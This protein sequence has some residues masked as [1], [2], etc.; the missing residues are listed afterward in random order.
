M[1]E[2]ALEA[3]AA[4]RRLGGRGAAVSARRAA[5]ALLG[6]VAVSTVV[7]YLLARELHGPFVFMDEL[8]YERMALSLARSGHFDLFGH[9]G[10]AYSPLYPALLAPVYAVAHSAATADRAVVALNAL[11]MS[12]AAVP[13][14]AIARSLLSRR[15][16]LGAAALSLAAP[17]MYYSALRLSEA[18]AYPLFLAAVWA[19]LRTLREPGAGNDALLLVAIALA[20]GARL[21]Q[22]ALVPA[23]LTAIVLVELLSP[24]AGGRLR[25]V[26]RE[27]ARHRLL[28][29]VTV[30]GA[31][32]V[33]ARTLVNG[34][35]LPLAGRYAV[36][37]N[38]RPSPLRV[39][40]LAVRHLAGLDLAVGVLPFA[41]ALAAAWLFARRGLP[42]TAVPFAAIALACTFW[43]VLEVA[44]DAAAFDLPGLGRTGDLPRIH[45]RYL[46]YLVPF[47]LV[48][49]VASLRARPGIRTL[50]GAAAAAAALPAAIPF[51]LVVN[52]TIVADTFSLQALA[53]VDRNGL[54]VPVA[55]A[56][57]I[58]VGAAALLAFLYAFGAAR[59]PVLAVLATVAVFAYVS[60]AERQRLLSAA[61][62]P[63]LVLPEQQ[64]DWVD[65]IV[66]PDGSVAILDAGRARPLA[67]RETAYYNFS[68]SRVYSACRGAFGG[69]FGERRVTVDSGGAVWS[70]GALLRAQY[71]VAD[72]SVQPHGRMLAANLPG[73][74][75]LVAPPDGIVQVGSGAA[76]AR[77][78]G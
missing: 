55:D 17:L 39:A 25:S 27:L 51:H 36:V 18:L 34:G 28:V 33:L 4:A 58:A 9:T 41:A 30:A 78:R 48:A 47:F 64:H 22:V 76:A 21:Q 69:D 24:P 72:S 26:L 40:E 31:L 77:C 65:R 44:Y 14:Y 32:A 73:G 59:R 12:A 52:N 61:T 66:G 35:A 20:C 53:R 19:L 37:G 10:L 56:R 60:A 57:A 16:A 67:L 63:D 54:F 70:D 2:R 74:L 15:L 23:A 5:L 11:L 6:L 71:L 50:V 43:V 3:A 13:V 8:G 38:V 49:L 46:I 1:T 42:R 7:R 62:A 29:G 75:V 45:E 68:V